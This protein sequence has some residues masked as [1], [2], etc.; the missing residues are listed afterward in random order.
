[1]DHSVIRSIRGR[2]SV[3][4]EFITLVGASG[5]LITLWK[6]DFFVMVESKIISQRYILLLGELKL[7]KLKCGFRNIYALNDKYSACH[8][9]F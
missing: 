5:V 2:K 6:E 1:M 4:G 8:Y 3:K 7:L 9:S